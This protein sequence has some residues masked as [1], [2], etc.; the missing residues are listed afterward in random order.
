MTMSADNFSRQC[1]W[2]SS[3]EWKLTIFFSFQRQ[4]AVGKFSSLTK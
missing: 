4:S 3:F 2:N 1:A